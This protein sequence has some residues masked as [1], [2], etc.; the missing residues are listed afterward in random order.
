[1]KKI[2]T[3]ILLGLFLTGIVLP[4]FVVAEKFEAIEGCKAWKT[5]V[6]PGKLKSPT[7]TIDLTILKTGD[8]TPLLYQ[9][10][11]I[12]CLV[13]AVNKI[14]DIIF[15]IIFSI[16]VVFIAIGAFFY[17][18]SYGDPNRTAKGRN[19]IV[20]AMVGIVIAAFARI[21]PAIVKYIVF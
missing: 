15:F 5:M 14:T 6:I 18:V 8:I 4:V 1:M 19:F 3:L 20:F 10:W 13:N 21:I 2:L 12:I 9:G 11:G 17:L 7:Q 16:S